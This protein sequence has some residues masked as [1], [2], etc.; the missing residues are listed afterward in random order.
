VIHHSKNPTTIRDVAKQ[1]GVSVA[2]VSRVINQNTPV[3]EE[4]EQRVHNVMRELH[5]FPKTA[6]RNLS[7]QKTNAIGF[8]L[9][10]MVGGFFAPLLSGIEMFA[11]QHGYQLLIATTRYQFKSSDFSLPL[12]PHNT[13][14]L[15][16]Y[17]NSLPE[18]RIHTLYEMNYP[19]VLIHR[20]PPQSLVIP[21]VTIENKQ[22]TEDVISHLIE[23]HQRKRIVLLR[24]PRA[25][26]DSH[27]RELGFLQAHTR[28][29]L[30]VFD[31]LLLP[32]EFNQEV[33]FNSIRHLVENKIPFDAIFS[34]DDEAAVGALNALNHFGI[35]C[36][37]EVSLVG[38]DDQNIAS[39]LSPKLTTVYAPTQD[40]GRVAAEQLISIL[41]GEVPDSL[42]L[43]PTQMIIRKSCG[44]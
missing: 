3:S 8:I 27:W 14:G 37:Q 24:G 18:D 7:T 13:D 26:E 31:E 12:G 44:C 19:M 40:V 2:T 41:N 23:I 5:Y 15:L 1:A 25:E 6:A 38:F 9:Y 20:T 21:S 33:A 30:P 32:G 43:L 16:I 35:G 34:G 39:C 22:A 28:H 4:V 42:T 29:N 36:P 10:D 17:A 11:S